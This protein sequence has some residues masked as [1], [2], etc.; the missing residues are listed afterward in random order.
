MQHLSP[1]ALRYSIIT[2]ILSLPSNFF[3][4]NINCM[5]PS[6][7]FTFS[8]ISLIFLSLSRNRWRY[9]VILEGGIAC[10]SAENSTYIFL[11]AFDNSSDTDR[12][13]WCPSYLLNE[14]ENKTCLSAYTNQSTV[15]F[16]ICIYGSN[17]TF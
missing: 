17:E 9:T 12:E 3:P 5:G 14:T 10:I 15:V 2:T 1:L 16:T 4:S 13:D 8:S 7:H 6:S 11:A